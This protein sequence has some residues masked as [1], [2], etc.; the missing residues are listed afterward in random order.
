MNPSD[1]VPPRLLA[2]ARAVLASGGGWNG[3]TRGQVLALCAMHGVDPAQLVGALAGDGG[4]PMPGATA[5]EAGGAVDASVASGPGAG[6]GRSPDA[7]GA[8]PVAAGERSERSSGGIASGI[9]LLVVAAGCSVALVA[10]ALMRAPPVAPPVVRPSPVSTDAPPPGAARRGPVQGTVA[11][12]ASR[13]AEVARA[14][15][16]AATAPPVPAMYATPPALTRGSADTLARRSLEGFSGDEPEL[17]SIARRAAAGGIPDEAD[18][19]TAVRAE[20]AFRGAWPL[21]D[22]RR[23]AASVAAMAGIRRAAAADARGVRRQDADPSEGGTDPMSLWR[24][25]AGAGLDAAFAAPV[26]AAASAFDAS[27]AQ[28]LASRTATVAGAVLGGDPPRAADAVDAWLRAVQA[29]DAADGPALADE[30]VLAM[31][32]EL[33]RRGAPIDRPGVSADAA[34]TLLA[35]LP[36]DG[37][38]VRRDRVAA[39]FRAWCGDPAVGSPALHGLTSVMAAVRP[40]A[41]WDPWIVVPAR[42]DPEA[43]ALAA[44]RMA[45]AVA[46]ASAAPARAVAPWRRGV[47]AEIERSVRRAAARASRPGAAEGDAERILRVAESLAV[48]EAIRLLERGQVSGAEATLSRLT[49]SEGLRLADSARWRN[50]VEPEPLRSMSTDGG[51]AARLRA[52]ASTEESL[53]AVRELRR[54]PS[55]DR[56][57]EDAAAIARAV[58]SAGSPQLRSQLRA[59]LAS[60][61]PRGPNVAA[62]LAAEALRAPDGGEVVLLVEELAGTRLPD[63]TDSRRRDAAVAWLLDHADGMEPSARHRVDAAARVISLSASAVAS[64]L[65]GAGA[66]PGAPPEAALRA[67]LDADLAA[68]GPVLPPREAAAVASAAD[69]RRRLA[70]PGPQAAVAELTSLLDLAAAVAAERDPA[71][72]PQVEDAVRAASSARR[73][74]ADAIA[75]L[76]ATARALLRVALGDDG[77]GEAPR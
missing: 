27:A 26:A 3:R 53:D 19:A 44:D 17:L 24:G 41:W 73:G 36:W 46:S 18:R 74:A 51:V 76:D 7:T 20:E 10:F 37:S 64:A 65:G 30:R 34:G 49:A 33:L 50:G 55:G 1:P 35:A 61:F 16:G 62:A 14:T 6:A 56:G 5:V 11:S 57:P 69:A 72:A 23:R 54:D 52:G 8:A 25:A 58:L 60:T 32:G 48:V 75:Q 67:W 66:P 43:R 70:V 47:P 63:G 15:A 31:L 71:C 13:P 39:E 40:G 22:S 21:L 42:A 77:P 59:A 38:R 29:L 12:P 45:A 68:T 28:W 9:A 4:V 2:D